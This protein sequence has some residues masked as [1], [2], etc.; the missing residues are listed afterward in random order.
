MPVAA[1][2]LVDESPAAAIIAARDTSA[3][4]DSIKAVAKTL[5]VG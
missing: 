2:A 4:R 1:A 3:L 5:A